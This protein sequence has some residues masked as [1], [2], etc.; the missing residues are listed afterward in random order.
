MRLQAGRIEIGTAR[1]IK[2]IQVEPF[3]VA[4]FPV[5][6]VKRDPVL[7]VKC[8]GREPHVEERQ[9]LMPRGAFVA[10]DILHEN[11]RAGRCHVDAEFLPELP[12]DGSLGGLSELYCPS[13]RTDA[14]YTTGIVMDLRREQ[15]AIA[16]VKAQRLHTYSGAGAPLGHQAA[17]SR[18]SPRR[19]WVQGGHTA[20][21]VF[22]G[23]TQV[24]KARSRAFT[25]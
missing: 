24:R 23:T 22:A 9:N 10:V 20:T 17:V 12:D 2:V 25:P 8:S 7:A 18:A 13:E 11:R 5:M 15:S 21:E 6:L 14:L 16:P 4:D 3:R 1:A 19:Q